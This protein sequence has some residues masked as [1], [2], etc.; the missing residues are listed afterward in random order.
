MSAR[1]REG[2][3]GVAILIGV[4]VLSLFLSFLPADVTNEEAGSVRSSRPLGRRALYLLLHETGFDARAFADAPRDLPRDQSLLWL[5]RAP[6]ANMPGRRSEFFGSSSPERVGLHRLDFY[7]TFVE[8]GGTIV[9]AADEENRTRDFLVDALGIDEANELEVDDD[10]DEDVEHVRT[11]GGEVVEM[12]GN[13]SGALK[14]LDP[15]ASPRTLWTIEHDESASPFAIEFP[16]GLGSVVVL[17]SDEFVENR[18]IGERQHALAAVRLVEELSKGGP[19]LFSEYEAGRWDPPSTMSL[20]FGPSLLLASLHGLV[21]LG[22]FVWMQGFARAFARD[23]E[24]LALFSPYLRARSLAHVLT[25]GKRTR[26][27]AALLR[28]GALERWRALYRVRGRRPVAAEA[29][30]SSLPI[31]TEQEV[32]EFA[33]A[34]GVVDLEPR[35]K[36]LLVVQVK[37]GVPDLDALDRQ[38]AALERELDGRLRGRGAAL[39]SGDP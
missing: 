4:V 1:R 30:A 21:L 7:R 28:S 20:L 13:V 17:A 27:L 34:A 19:I 31:V 16:S 35:L 39:R 32:A 29:S 12:A 3:F 22:L 24:P 9:L 10:F 25:R 38:L 23:P 11:G 36:E 15:N 33:R 6:T 14:E 26:T 18:H 8:S 2:V 37:T 5:P